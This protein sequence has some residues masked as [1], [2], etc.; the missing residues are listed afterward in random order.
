[1]AL[2]TS[3][4]GVLDYHASE[5]PAASSHLILWCYVIL[6]VSKTTLFE[7]FYINVYMRSFSFALVTV[8]IVGFVGNAQTPKCAAFLLDTETVFIDEERMPIPGLT[9]NSFTQ[10][11]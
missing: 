4:C 1:V 6:F 2:T 11:I 10:K 7:T 8:L 3:I 9:E 5:T